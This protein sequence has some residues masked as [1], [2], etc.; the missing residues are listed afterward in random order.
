[1]SSRLGKLAVCW[2]VL[3]LVAFPAGAAEHSGEAPEDTLRVIAHIAASW[4][5]GN[6]VVEPMV[7]VDNE[8][9]FV[10]RLAERW[11]ITD[12][13]MD[14]YLRQGVVF[15]DGTP[16]TSRSVL[17]NWER[18]VE[19]AAQVAP[20]S[21]LDLRMAVRDVEPLGDHM[22]RMHFKPDGYV[23]QMLVYLRAFYMYSPSY[24]EHTAGRYPPGNQ[25]NILQVGPWGT[26][27]YIVRE[28]SGGGA[29]STLERNPDY[30]RAGYPRTSRLLIHG[31]AA[32]DSQTAYQWM[33]DGKADL[34][35]AGTPSML[36]LLAGHA[37]LHRVIAYPTSH[38]TTLYNTRKPD[39]PLSDIRVRQALNFLVDRHTLLRY[40]SR[41]TARMVAFI[42]PLDEAEGLQPYPYDPQSA[43]EL[44]AEAG[45]GPE[46][47]LSIVVGYFISEEKLALAITAMLRA[48]GV[49]V[50]LERYVTRQEYYQRIKNYT[51]GPDNPIEAERWDLSIVQSGL[52]TNTVA[53][54]FE[55]FFNDGGNRWIE[56]DHQAD[57][58]FLAAMR[59]K[60]PEG[61]HDALAEMEIHLYD[62]HYSMPLFIW[63]SIFVMNR[64]I[65]QNSFS[66]SGYLLNLGEIA[67][68]P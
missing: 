44:L 28:I 29:L 59:A 27:P 4:V 54:H 10:P 21:T 19:T 36:P 33:I 16:F 38:L 7:G 18:Y 49:E 52:Y 17:H 58:L 51:H 61:V 34:F 12:T 62:Q 3:L 67:I 42:L 53:T 60:T 2:L 41:D 66:G 56:V 26:G 64:R 9:R 13:H 1:M 6:S 47:P 15:H 43:Q 57:D 40:V 48:G 32:V 25:A 55:A 35:D 14:L 11:E 39:T 22:V 23:G 31:P 68:D 20:Y 5:V 46:N 8:N 45:F 65:A 24:F 63:P 50:E 37:H 30:W